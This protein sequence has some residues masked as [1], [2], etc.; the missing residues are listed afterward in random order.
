MLACRGYVTVSRCAHEYQ[1][2]ALFRLW[3]GKG[4]A[5]Q[6]QLAAEL[7]ELLVQA[8]PGREVHGAGD[9]ALHGEALVIK[10]TTWTTRLPGQRGHL[11][12]EP[13]AD[14]AARSA[15]GDRGADRQVQGRRRRG[16][17]PGDRPDLRQAAEGA[18]R[19]VPGTVARQLQGR[20]GPARSD[21]RAGLGKPHDLG[22]F[23]LDTRLSAEAIERYS[24]RWPIEP[25]N[26]TGKQVTAA[27]LHAALRE[28][29]TSARINTISQRGG[30]SRETVTSTLTSEAQAA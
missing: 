12:A 16:L 30:E 11:R 1:L 3:P 27:D 15:A 5:S 19:R 8:F 24:W 28:V 10:G 20:S 22:I 17:A 29:L 6:V 25:S 26:A 18:G 7:T 2:P 21:A 23:T 9:A 14:R 4:T 13:P